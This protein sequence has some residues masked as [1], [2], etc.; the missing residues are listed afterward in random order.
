M[1]ALFVL[2]RIFGL[3]PNESDK[4][5]SILATLHLIMFNIPLLF[6]TLPA[7]VYWYVNQKTVDISDVTNVIYTVGV[8]G[9]LTSI[10]MY[11]G[12]SKFELRDIICEL[13]IVVNERETNLS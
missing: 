8:F 11:L 2:L 9:M 6:V 4:K 12:W 10:Y 3:F 7:L 13:S 1:S 5:H